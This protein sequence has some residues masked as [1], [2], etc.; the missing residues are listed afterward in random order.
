[1]KDK[2]IPAGSYEFDVTF[3]SSSKVL[4]ENEEIYIFI[5]GSKKIK[6]LFSVETILPDIQIL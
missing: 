1:M 5:R 2:I 6:L 4:Y 3:C